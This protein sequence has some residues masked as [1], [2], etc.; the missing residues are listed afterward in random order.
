MGG[1]QP[2]EELHGWQHSLKMMKQLNIRTVGGMAGKAVS[3]YISAQLADKAGKAV[4]QICTT[5]SI[6]EH[7]KCGDMQ[8]RS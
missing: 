5:A 6:A 2:E 1:E 3:N 7:G 4:K 8:S